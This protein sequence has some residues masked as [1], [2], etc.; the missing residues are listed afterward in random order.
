[1]LIMSIKI[2]QMEKHASYVR[3]GRKVPCQE[4]RNVMTVSAAVTG[5]LR[6]CIIVIN[7][8]QGATIVC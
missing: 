8:K 6:E 2:N 5:H 3:R 7:A 1:V 4:V